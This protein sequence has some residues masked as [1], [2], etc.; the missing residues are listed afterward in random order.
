MYY[1]WHQKRAFP[2]LLEVESGVHELRRQNIRVDAVDFSLLLQ[3]EI[4]TLHE[5]HRDRIIIYTGSC[6]L[7]DASVQ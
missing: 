1:K 3:G 2:H 7:L 4:A 5:L 6:G